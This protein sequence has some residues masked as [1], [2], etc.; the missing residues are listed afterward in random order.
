[1]QNEQKLRFDDGA[2]YE[3]MMGKW[4]QLTADIFLDWLAPPQSARWLDV[5]CGNG[6]FTE[7]IV[8]R[9]AP[10]AVSGIDP[11][12]GQLAYARTRP[13]ARSAKFS[14][15]D[16]MSLDFH[17]DSFDVAI[18]ALV[19]FFVPEPAKGVAEMARVVCPG[20][21]VAAYAWDVLGGGLPFEPIE[22]EMR[23]MGFIP[24]R[25][26]SVETSRIAILR[27]LWIGAG[28]AAVETRAITVQRSFEDFDD[29]WIASTMAPS[30]G[31]RVAA[32]TASD[33]EVLKHRVR[34]LMPSDAAGQIICNARANAV[35]GRVKG[36]THD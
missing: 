23:A 7:K 32:M 13:S 18:M 5:G 34:S 8:Q 30:I 15:G 26:P 28:F 21:I 20:G 29:F 31:P 10:T 3:R 14:Q 27:D 4:S 24:L 19:I 9:C 1:M 36:V 25:P 6:A 33:A 2:V 16:A 35:R 12:D 22:A 11:S 17:D